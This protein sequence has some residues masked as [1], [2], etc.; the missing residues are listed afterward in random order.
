MKGIIYRWTCKLDGKNYIGQTVN[1]RKRYLQHYNA[2]NRD[3][4]L[5]DRAIYKKGV[6]NFEYAVLLTVHA[7]TREELRRLLDEAEI[8]FI[9]IYQSHMSTGKGYNMTWGGMSRGSYTHTE[10]TR[11]KLSRIMKGKKRSSAARKSVSEGLKGLKKSEQH[12]ANIQAAHKADMKR[13]RQ[14]TVDEVLVAEYPSI[15]AAERTTGINRGGIS[16]C[17]NGRQQRTTGRDGVS[18][19]WKLN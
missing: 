18:Y 1:P 12:R 8:A 2:E 15:K 3:V 11:Q 7:E 17:I 9:R 10:E 13:V 19:T 14:C 4:Q 16:A 6:E 5:I